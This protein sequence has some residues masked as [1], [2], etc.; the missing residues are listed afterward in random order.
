LEIECFCPDEKS[1]HG[2]QTPKL[3]S[4]LLPPLKMESFPHENILDTPLTVETLNTFF[5]P[6]Y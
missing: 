1:S 3:V 2:G 5:L 4:L 6:L